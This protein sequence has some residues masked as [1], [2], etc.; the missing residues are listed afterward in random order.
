LLAFLVF[1]SWDVKQSRQRLFTFIQTKG[2]IHG[3][4]STK[5]LA[6]GCSWMHA[7]AWEEEVGFEIQTSTARRLRPSQRSSVSLTRR[8][9]VRNHSHMHSTHAYLQQPHTHVRCHAYLFRPLPNLA[10]VGDH[11]VFEE[12]TT[13]DASSLLLLACSSREEGELNVRWDDDYR[14]L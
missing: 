13:C 9:Q 12:V 6:F 14:N 4:R 3:S 5:A 7:C 11:L 2:C 8:K 1:C 10:R